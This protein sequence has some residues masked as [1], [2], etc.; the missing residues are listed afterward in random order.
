[1]SRTLTLLA[2]LPLTTSLLA[3]SGGPDA[4]GYTWKDSNEPDG[5]VFNWIDI[6]TTGT[7]VQGLA[8]DNSVG[9]FVMETDHPFYWYGRKFLWIG[10]NGYLCFNDGNLASPFP[11]IPTAG[12]VNDYIAGMT[13]DLNFLGVDNPGR[14]YFYDDADQTI[15]AYVGVPFWAPPPGSTYTG[16]NTFEIILSKTDSSITVQYLESLGI[17]QNGDLKVGIESVAGSIGLQ[18]SANVYQP[19]NYAVRF[20]MPIAS[21]LEVK[22]AA[23]KWNTDVTSGGFFRP[24]NGAPIAMITNVL[25]TGNVDVDAFNVQGQVLNAAG[26]VQVSEQLP[27]GTLLPGLDTTVN[28]NPFF[29]PVNPGTFS[30]RT[31]ISGLVGELVPDNNQLTQEIVVI[32]TTTLTQDLH[33]HGIVDDAIGLSWNGGNGGVAVY[34]RPPY[35]PAYATHTTVRIL[36]NTGLAG[37]TMKV[38]DDDGPGG[39]QG[40]LLDSLQIP[41]DLATLGDQVIP[42][43]APLEIHTGGVYVEWY[44]LGANIS[45]AQDINPPFSLRTY[46]VV[47]GVWAEYRDREHIDFFLGLRLEQA[48]VFDVGCTG[49]FA[50]IDGQEIGSATTVRAWVANFGNQP[51]T[52]FPVN[53]RYGNGPVVTQSYSGTAI[54]PGEQILFTF[55]QPLLPVADATDNLCVWS[56]WNIDDDVLNDTTCINL[57]TWVGLEES[58][59]LHATLAPNPANDH[60]RIEGLPAGDY[61]LR[62]FDATGRQVMAEQ[63]TAG[64]A[65]L[66]VDVTTLR[67]GT[68]QLR[69]HSDTGTFQTPFVVQR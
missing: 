53:Y 39:L 12:G 9:P 11:F 6:T 31:T 20:Y 32:D 50:P 17:T 61:D 49:F 33:Y 66:R 60:L 15:V 46:E 37:Y 1:M 2:L 35:Y 22:D 67:A 29:D 51:A 30:F 55:T 42:L 14:C 3:L 56:S 68:Y 4:Y 5:P 26:V 69:L 59:R 57:V 65:P 7:L 54:D 36:A 48:P 23:I 47:D 27:L 21:T 45:I 52:N 24:R 40:T 19:A 41:P 44:M 64:S 38:Y 8:D 58:T 10:S 25:N 62:L 63:R 18:H 16:S 43:S 34:I 13:A 28:F